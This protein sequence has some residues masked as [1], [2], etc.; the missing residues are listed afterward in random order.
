MVGDTPLEVDVVGPVVVVVVVVAAAGVTEIDGPS[1]TTE[2][3]PATLICDEVVVHRPLASAEAVAVAEIEADWLVA[4]AVHVHETLDSPGAEM[5]THALSGPVVVTPD[6]DSVPVA[7]PVN[8]S[9]TLAGGVPGGA[10]GATTN[11]AV[12]GVVPPAGRAVEPTVIVPVVMAL[13]GPEVAAITI[14]PVATA[15]APTAMMTGGRRTA[16]LLTQQ[17]PLPAHHPRAPHG[18]TRRSR[19]AGLQVPRLGVHLS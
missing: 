18:Q 7:P 19:R 2:V 15:A 17:D 5:L 14:S 9:V 13:A 6:S 11:V 8:V 12:T 1:A 16:S 4:G 3:A 10:G